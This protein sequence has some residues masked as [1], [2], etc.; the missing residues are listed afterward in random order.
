[1]HDASY[2]PNIGQKDGE[3]TIHFTALFEQRSDKEP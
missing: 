3:F 2:A 1:M